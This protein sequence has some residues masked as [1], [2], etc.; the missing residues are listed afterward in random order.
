MK[1]ILFI[2]SIFSISLSVFALPFN[3]ELKNDEKKKLEAGEVLIRNID[4]PKY[5]CLK[6]Q[7]EACKKIIKSINETKP[8][9]LAEVIQI[10]PYK[11]NED[12]P[13]KIR[14][15]LENIQDYAGIPYW[16]EHH[17]RYWDLYSSSEILSRKEDGNKTW[18]D[19]KLYMEPFG[20]IFSPIYIEEEPFSLS[21]AGKNSGE[22][23]KGYIF[24]TQTNTNNLKFEGITC[25]KSYCMKSAIILFRE[26]DNWILYGAGGVKAPRVPFL[27][28][29][30]ETSFI[31]R[32]KTFCNFIF[33]KI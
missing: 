32:I 18:L 25:V 29:R 30:I 16:S 9:Y 7:N 5:M 28:P 8:N 24:Y 17:Q 26:G 6:E 15:A 4:Y 22:D 2:F 20:D 14:S 23:D 10:K 13:K 27:T 12:L 3:S 1:K 21:N 19:T 31:N 11:G 33:T